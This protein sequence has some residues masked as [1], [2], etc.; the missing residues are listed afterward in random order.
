[1]VQKRRRYDTILVNITIVKNVNRQK[2]QD[3]ITE[4]KHMI[5]ICIN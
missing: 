2:C 4:K 1:M 3:D 5:S